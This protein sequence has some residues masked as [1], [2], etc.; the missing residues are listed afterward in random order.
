MHETNN[1]LS[2]EAAIAMALLVGPHRLCVRV[3]AANCLS[4]MSQTARADV[5]AIQDRIGYAS[6]PPCVDVS[7]PQ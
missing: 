6:A 1:E 4:R 3:D 5:H 2:G 7:A